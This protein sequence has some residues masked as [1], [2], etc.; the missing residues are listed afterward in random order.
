MLDRDDPRNRTRY[1]VLWNE[2]TGSYCVVDQQ[3]K[4]YDHMRGRVAMWA[5]LLARS[6]VPMFFKMIGVTYD[7][8]GTMHDASSWRPNDI[9]DFEVTLRAYIKKYFPAI[10]LYGYAWVSEIQPIS[11]G[12][13]Y[14]LV[15]ATSKRLHFTRN[16][17]EGLWS[18][19]FSKVTVAHSPYYLVSYVKK[20]DQKDYFYFPFK[21]RGFAVFIAGAVL[22]GGQQARLMMR[23]NFLKHWQMKE[24]LDHY[25]DDGYFNLGRVKDA[26][27]PPSDWQWA[28]SYVNDW[29][30]VDR[31]AELTEEF[32]IHHPSN[33]I[34]S[35]VNAVQ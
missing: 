11:K 31:A 28:G 18:H 10:I 9:R 25:E 33:V 29:A 13:H 19:G 35:A 34:A 12:Y 7:K 27:P 22:C 6:E 15:L 8:L 24:I 21:A 17:I 5:Q 32:L 26:R 1:T 14:H 2:Q 4:R 23:L 16:A 3:K 20:Q 30:A